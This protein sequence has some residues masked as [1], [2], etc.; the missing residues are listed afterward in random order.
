ALELFEQIRSRLHTAVAQRSLAEVLRAYG[1]DDD[2]GRRAESLFRKSLQSFE[3]LGAEI[4][5]A[6]TGKELAEFL[7]E[8]PDGRKPSPSVFAEADGL[9]ARAEDIFEKIKRDSDAAPMPVT[10][11]RLTA[12]GPGYS[13]MRPPSVVPTGNPS[14]SVA[15]PSLDPSP[16]V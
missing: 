12:T 15:A 4:E 10:D 3:E 11:P 14:V 5:F 9:R 2:K 6:R 16:P 1:R 7:V 8:S 13:R